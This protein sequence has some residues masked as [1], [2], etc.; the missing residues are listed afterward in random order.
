MDI[1]TIE[2]V[3]LEERE[4]NSC[5]NASANACQTCK[6][7]FNEM[8]E[9]TRLERVRVERAAIPRHLGRPVWLT[10][11][12]RVEHNAAKLSAHNS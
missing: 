2:H 10:R 5:F 4:A 3:L 7:P 1:G 12:G 8:V 11:F 9:D 6:P